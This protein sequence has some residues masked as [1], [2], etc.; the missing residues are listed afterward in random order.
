M[1]QLKRI[2]DVLVDHDVEFIV[3]GGLAAVL[4]GA[5]VTTQDVDIVYGLSEA[6]QGRLL[7]ALEVLGAVFRGDARRLSP[8]LSHLASRGHKLLTTRYGDLDC[9]G[10]IEEA[11]THEELLPH[12]EWM[13]LGDRQLR[14]L[15][16]ARL[17]RVKEQLTR[18]KDK[19]MLLQLQATF[20]ERQK[21]AP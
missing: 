16:L 19:L 5:P 13:Q 2:L 9:L 14:V 6:N 4:Q 21:K 11:T 12:A 1:S 10:A 18:P 20:D 15:S 3:V 17:I 8:N 7:A